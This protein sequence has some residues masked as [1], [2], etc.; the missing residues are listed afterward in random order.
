[1]KK[2]AQ[3]LEGEAVLSRLVND[4]EGVGFSFQLVPSL[5]Y[6]ISFRWRMMQAKH[7]LTLTHPPREASQ[8]KHTLT[9]TH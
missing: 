4:V 1:M 8:A 9:L 6:N 7:T 5:T 3:Q 2:T